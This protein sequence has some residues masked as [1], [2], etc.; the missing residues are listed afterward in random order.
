MHIAALFTAISLLAAPS[1]PSR[2]Q[3]LVDPHAGGLTVAMGEWTLVPEAK[4][5]RPGQV[6][7]VVTNRG[8]FAHGFR[9]RSAGS[10][11]D[12]FEARGML[13]Q[14][15]QTGR[16]TVDLAAGA[17]DIECYVEDAHGDHEELGMHS[18]LDV[19]AD[20]PFVKP[21]TA[22]TKA[23]NQVKI[24]A[25][26]FNPSPV[27]VKRGTTVRWTNQDPAPHTVS[28][29]SG[30]FTS[31]QLKKGQAYSRKFASTG[32]FVYLCAVH[33]SMQGRVVVSK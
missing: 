5:I 26:K 28:A 2:P 32:T 8:R 11:K 18:P 10:G 31:A 22:T 19:R 30:A 25:F 4:A 23:P 17:Y 14:P 13:L 16:L 33:P 6:T 1:A 15:G 27:K 7:F 12:R 20:A 3:A 9:I 29:K 21:P 24:A